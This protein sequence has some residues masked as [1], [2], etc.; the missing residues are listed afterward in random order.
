MKRPRKAA[1]FA[2]VTR[3]DGNMIVDRAGTLAA[4]NTY[5]GPTEINSGTLQI[6]APMLE[7]FVASE[8]GSKVMP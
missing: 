8:E 3:D 4:T 7:I 6:D 2:T 1:I 5:C